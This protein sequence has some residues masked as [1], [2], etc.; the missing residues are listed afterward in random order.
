MKLIRTICV[1]GLAL[2]LATSVYA[3]TQ[4]VKVSGDVIARGI[5]RSDYDLDANND[6]DT[7]STTLMLVGSNNW[8]N[9]FMTNTEVQ[10]DADLTDNVSA[11]VRLFNQRDWDDS[12]ATSSEFDIGVDLMYVELKEFL[13]SPLTLRIGRQDIWLG[14]GF[15]IGANIADPNTA[16][17][18]HEYSSVTSF[19]AV[20]ATLDYDPWTI[21]A[22]GVILAEGG[23]ASN[24]DNSIVGVNA[25]YLFDVYNAEAEG[26]WFY[27][28]DANT[29]PSTFLNT[30]NTVH[31]FGVR[32]SVDPID[33]W[34]AAVEGAVQLGDYVGLA[35]QR[36]DRKR[37][38]WALDV[39]A[40]C[41]YFK[42]RFA[43]KPVIGA[44]YIFFSGDDDSDPTTDS[45]GTYGGWD[46]MYR[47]KFESKIR[48]FYGLYYGSAMTSGEP[49][50]LNPESALTNQHSICLYGSIE[51]ADS[52][53]IDA[54]FFAY[55][56]PEGR[57]INDS[58]ALSFGDRD[59]FIG[60]EVDLELT[61]DYTEDVSF[62]LVSAWFFPGDF[63]AGSY[64]DN[65][66]DVVGSM[67]LSF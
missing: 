3:G 46:V 66:A 6:E 44:E 26:Y 65:A 19:D 51:P 24:D 39:E 21:D 55:W 5:F 27:K 59:E 64:D 48:E 25:G 10:I 28:N 29:T 56:Q 8:Q 23:I 32:G 53:M 49:V 11:V 13:Y 62:G 22:I 50:A 61:W 7:T 60:T 47:G 9:Y 54:K 37:L 38:G 67:T 36:Q 17:N 57:T 52:L 4:S 58:S 34:T 43:W 18:A 42:D 15:I 45:S 16:I 31:T 33:D 40:E 35:A 2:C 1:L 30:H 20:R 14:R 12:T 63:Y 41:R